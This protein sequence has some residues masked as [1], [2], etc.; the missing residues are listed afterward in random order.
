ME[1]RDAPESS[2]DSRA[3][4]A[5]NDLAWQS[6]KSCPKGKAGARR[7]SP[8]H[9]THPSELPEPRKATSLGNKPPRRA[10][11]EDTGM[12]AVSPDAGLGDGLAAR[13]GTEKRSPA[14]GRVERPDLG[15]GRALKA[16]KG[17]TR[18]PQTGWPS[19]QPTTPVETAGPG[20]LPPRRRLL[21]GGVGVGLGVGNRR[22]P[23]LAGGGG[24]GPQGE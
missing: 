15:P 1:A 20:L 6:E 19:A 2:L 14:G 7:G 21:C 12:N 4:T 18:R 17:R 24:A 5:E 22:R 16:E 23:G 13:E 9:H 10:G 8:G 11:P 3:S